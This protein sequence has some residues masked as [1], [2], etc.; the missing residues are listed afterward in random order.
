MKLILFSSKYNAGLVLGLTL[1][2]SLVCCRREFKLQKIVALTFESY[3]YEIYAY[4]KNKQN[5]AKIKLNAQT[6]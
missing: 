2:M 4:A 3:D 1:R 6:T 5:F